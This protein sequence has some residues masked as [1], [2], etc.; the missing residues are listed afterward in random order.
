MIAIIGIVVVFGAVVGGFL[1]EKGHLPVL[2]QPA[3]LLI[4]CGGAIGS[5]LIPKLMRKYQSPDERELDAGSTAGLFAHAGFD[6]RTDFYDFV[7]SPLAGLLPGWE[8]GYRLARRLDDI[9][10]RVPLLGRLGSNF[11]VIARKP[12]RV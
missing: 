7:S 1:M 11:E 3:E 5:L 4:I 6:T 9:I 10:V 12:R 8:M 2:V